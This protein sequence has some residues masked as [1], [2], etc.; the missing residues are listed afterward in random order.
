MTLK[1]AVSIR[2]RH[3]CDLSLVLQPDSSTKL[4]QQLSANSIENQLAAEAHDERIG[5]L[6]DK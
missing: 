1:S 4:H 3:S 2:H 5:G 6:L